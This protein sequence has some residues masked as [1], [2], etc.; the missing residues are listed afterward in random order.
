M[1]N[2]AIAILDASGSM[3]GQE[4]RV[5]T[6]MNEYVNGLPKKTR[7]SVFLFDS[8][9]WHEHFS[10][11]VKNWT[12]MTTEHYRAGAMTPLFDSIAKG[13]EFVGGNAGKGDKVMVMIDTD[14]YENQSS[15]YDHDKIKALIDKKK[16]KGWEFL[17]MA[18]GIDEATATKVGGTGKSLG[19]RTMA[20]SYAGRSKAYGFASSLTS[21]YFDGKTG[22]DTDAKPKKGKIKSATATADA[23]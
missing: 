15:D 7:L 8:E 10:G 3:S 19:I 2:H 13:I 5:V 4:E 6:S 23:K 18:N 16:G 20:T 12:P 11:K 17:F 1:T 14:G 9:R 21:E 22:D